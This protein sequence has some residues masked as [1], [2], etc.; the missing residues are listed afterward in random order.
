MNEASKAM[1]RREIEDRLGIFNWS[2][3]FV[4]SGIDVGCGPDKIKYS[5][6]IPFDFE[7]G[8]ANYISK[9]FTKQFDYLHASQ[10][11]EHMHN[12]Y[13][14]IIEWL[15]IIKVGGHAIISIPDWVL[16]EGEVWPSRYNPDHKST[17]SF[18]RESSP[19]KNH[20]NIYKFLQYLQPF[21]YPKRALL[22]DNNYN[23]R[24][25]ASVDQTFNETDNV[26]AFIEIVLCKT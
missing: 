20:V 26:E 1:R 6:C 17:W 22:V 14:A 19:S 23:Y 16:Y 15:K 13:D 8:D 18:T 11:L 9:Y 25:A 4:G 2:D 24:L 10:C 5:S 12:P 3:I 7:H 21:A